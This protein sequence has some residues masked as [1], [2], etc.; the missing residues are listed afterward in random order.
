MTGPELRRWI[1][2]QRARTPG[3]YRGYA[4]LLAA[5]AAGVALVATADDELGASRAWQLVAIVA[6]GW[7]MLVTPL[8][9]FWRSDASLLAR[10]PLGGRALFELAMAQAFRL[11]GGAALV[12][13]AAA[14]PLVQWSTDLCVRHVLTALALVIIVPTLIPA[15]A[16]G[17]AALVASGV[18]D[19]LARSMAGEFRAPTT[20]WLG[21]LPG[22]AAAAVVLL[23]LA[24]APWLRV[25][26]VTLIGPGPVALGAAV[27]A[28]LLAIAIAAARTDG[29]SF[30]LREVAALDRQRLAHIEINP[31]SPVERF[32]MRVLGRP[33]ATIYDKDAR[34]MRRR[35]PMA[36]VIGAGLWVV[37]V[38]VVL[39][40]PNAFVAWTVA[41]A[42]GGIAYALVSARRLV[43][44]PVEYPTLA[45][46][47]PVPARAQ[48]RAKT[49]WV[50]TWA[51]V[52]VVPP[53]AALLVAARR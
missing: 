51:L 47:L 27:G 31:P 42:A 35:F 48:G 15:V 34:M 6:F 20:S 28:G 12:A 25:G 13:V 24:L 38:G 17:A 49:A 36:W 37:G 9:I 40:E 50:A 16:V 46:T 52:F 45:R 4:V 19:S 41:V 5:A 29:L 53:L 8:R 14:V 18:V 43:T 26:T 30:A 11:A 2:R 39:A 1:G 44:P 33:T 7:A 3:R 32:V 10:L 22:L 23:V 21:V